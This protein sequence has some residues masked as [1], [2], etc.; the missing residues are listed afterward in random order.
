MSASLP[1]TG[2]MGRKPFQEATVHHAVARLTSDDGS[3]RFLVAD[4]VGLGKTLV[5][6]GVLQHLSERKRP[7]NVF[8]ICSSLTI[9][10]QN[11]DNL[12]E[13]LPKEQR[14]EAVV[15]VDRPTLLPWTTPSTAPPFTLFTLTPGTLPMNN[16]SRGRVDERASIWCLLREGLP[17]AG[18]A[19]GRVE[20]KLKLVQEK[21]WL[22]ELEKRSSGAMLDRI[23]DLAQPY[24]KDVREWLARPADSDAAIARALSDKLS[25]QSQFATIQILRKR[26]ARIGLERLRPDVVILDEFQRFFEVLE[27]LSLKT[28][29]GMED[30]RLD[31]DRDV[32]AEGLLQLLLGAPPGGSGPAILL[33]SATP[34]R[35][36]AGG[37]DG[38]G[39]RH[40]KQFFKLLEFLYAEKARERVPEL[41]TLFRKYGRLL[42]EAAPGSTEVLLLRDDIQSRLVEVIARTERASFL[43][44]YEQASSPD[45]Q[46]VALTT[47]DV[48][49][50]THLW[51]SASDEDKAAATPYWSSIP[52]PLQMMD[53]R[54]KLRE[55]ATP[56]CPTDSTLHLRA[57]L[58]RRYESMEPPHPRM[59]ALLSALPKA[60]LGLPWLP[61]SIPWWPLGAPFSEAQ[62]AANDVG[63]SKILLFSRF[64][65]VPRAVASL[66]S[67]EAER[68]IY[69]D[70]RRGRRYDYRARRRGG[71]EEAF[72][73]GEGLEALPSPSFSWQAR[74]SEAR[75][76]ELDHTLLSL[77]VPLSILAR[78]GN[79]QTLNGFATRG[80][81]KGNSLDQVTERLRAIFVRMGA[82]IIDGRRT[83]EGWRALVALERS[84][85]DSGAA[86]LDALTEWADR[87]ANKAAEAVVQAWIREARRPDARPGSLTITETDL[88]DIADLALVGPGNVLLRSVGRVFGPASEA[89][90]RLLRVMNVSIGALRPY[91][92]EPEFHLTLHLKGETAVNHPVNLRW[93][94]WNGNLES[95]L[96]EYLA[97]HA[98]LG[99]RDVDAGREVK[100]L[101]AL[102]QAL[103]VRVSTV[104]A[105][106]LDS[107]EP[108]SMRC[109]VGMPFG[110]TPDK[111]E[112]QDGVRETR[113]DALRKAFNSPFR[114]FVLATTSI[115]QEGLD[116]HAYCDHLVHWDLPASPVDLEQRDGRI[117]RYGG[118]SVRKALV[119]QAGEEYTLPT[120]ES[121]WMHFSRGFEERCGGMEP[122]WGTDGAR[123]RRTVFLPPLAKQAQELER[124]LIGLSHY[125]LALGQADPDEL[126]RSLERRLKDA[127]S[128]ARDALREWLLTARIDLSPARL[129]AVVTM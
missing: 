88:Q 111:D 120:S 56:E 124:L 74:Q 46:S 86:L 80:L 3:R 110:L 77:F 37:I 78:E 28:D 91:F 82:T 98:G 112:Q 108:F 73:P 18:D 5:A 76:Q 21:S 34:Y 60:M 43:R 17:H 38:M 116:F 62:G 128:E 4:E 93:A 117:N 15:D 54:Y 32:D 26:L 36:P 31:V 99:V 51:T 89:S 58:V 64:R 9:A 6:Q 22:Y 59:R 30:E 79:P 119:R 23:R 70:P 96:D 97:Q 123:I 53:K 126:L 84:S 81:S 87:S 90:D 40:Y 63:L 55:R 102:E 48:R 115:G 106:S 67:F 25:S 42:R 50:H 35:P 45:C 41:R 13:V 92:D 52:Y 85:Q 83:G 49:V 10:R 44:S 118:L 29:T 33:L 1:G 105:Q 65:A 16:S 61:P 47:S 8:Y 14:F 20:E 113:P 129:G 57:S 11:R 104:R 107:P 122:W 66:I 71:R 127:S 101:E 114:P 69:G 72:A 19:L 125:R 7:L 75:G 24:V 95:V 100:A 39:I 2:A 103:G 27:P 12:L 68:H 109:H 94:V 121:P